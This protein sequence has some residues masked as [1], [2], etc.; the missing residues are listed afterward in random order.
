MGYQVVSLSNRSKWADQAPTIE[1]KA[2]DEGWELAYKNW[3]AGHN[4][5]DSPEWKLGVVAHT[6]LVAASD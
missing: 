3:L 4:P 5:T 6:K 2:G 1:I